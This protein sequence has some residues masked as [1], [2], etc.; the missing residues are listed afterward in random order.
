MICEFEKLWR[1]DGMAVARGRASMKITAL[2]LEPT[3]GILFWHQY[4]QCQLYLRIDDY[5]AFVGGGGPPF[6]G[7]LSSFTFFLIILLPYSLTSTLSLWL[8]S[9]LATDDES[10]TWFENSGKNKPLHIGTVHLH[11]VIISKYNYTGTLLLRIEQLT[12]VHSMIIAWQDQAE[13]TISGGC[14]AYNSGGNWRLWTNRKSFWKLLKR[15]LFGFSM[16]SG[17]S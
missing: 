10:A 1:Y 12:P 14:N 13:L 11:C 2:T 16:K 8:F 9:F 6:I 15:I 5:P 17:T 3:F 7:S 4:K